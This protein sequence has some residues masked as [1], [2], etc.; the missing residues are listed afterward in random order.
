MTPLS[1]EASSM[2]GVSELDDVMDEEI[3]HLSHYRQKIATNERKCG[4]KGITRKQ[5]KMRFPH[6]FKKK[7]EK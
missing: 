3:N 4:E 7:D 5:A 2:F 6:M 1:K